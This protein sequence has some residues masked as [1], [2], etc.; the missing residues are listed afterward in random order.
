MRR[1]Q[2]LE[3]V[4]DPVKKLDD[5]QWWHLA[6]DYGYEVD[7]MAE[8]ANQVVMRRR[9]DRWNV[10]RLSGALLCLKEVVTHGAA[11]HAFP[12]LLQENVPW[13]VD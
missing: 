11:D 10:L 5:K 2:N 13:G 7:A 9:D 3:R 4:D 1:G 12:V 6:L 8:H